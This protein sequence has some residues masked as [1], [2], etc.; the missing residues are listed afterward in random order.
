MATYAIINSDNLVVRTIK[1]NNDVISVDGKENGQLG[2]AFLEQ[3]LG[4]DN[5]YVQYFY[6]DPEHLHAAVGDTYIADTNTFKGVQPFPSW[7]FNESLKKWE[8]PSPRPVPED[9]YCL[10]SETNQ[11]WYDSE[12]LLAFITAFDG[13]ETECQAFLSVA[14]A[15]N[16][17]PS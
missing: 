5:T 13:T 9:E 14:P 15:I 4:T 17:I 10:W 7:A 8:P 3:I 11:R 16:P 1:L 6:S 12:A 2:A